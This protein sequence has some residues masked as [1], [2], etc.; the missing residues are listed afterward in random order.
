MIE[1]LRTSDISQN[2]KN[3]IL[4]FYEY[5]KANG[6]SD[7]RL[8]RYIDVL[9]QEAKALKKDFK[10]TT[11]EDI[12][13]LLSNIRNRG[14]KDWTVQTHII[15]LKRFY[16]WLK[17]KEEFYPEEVKWI[18]TKMPKCNEH[19]KGEGA[20]ITKK[21]VEDMIKAAKNIMD[22]AFI[23]VIYESGCRIGE[24]GM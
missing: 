14:Y 16:K 20:L 6:M 21:D 10:D 1:N 4:G 2:N 8:G 9:S 18:R 12:I 7:A 24:I 22:K 5:A 19:L 11:K 3:A 13:A 23:S 17:G 15:L